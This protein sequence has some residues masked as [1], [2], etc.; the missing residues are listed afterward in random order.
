MLVA[1]ALCPLAVEPRRDAG[2]AGNAANCVIGD[3]AAELGV[4][5]D[6][7]AWTALLNVSPTFGGGGIIA[8]GDD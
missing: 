7:G 2:E 5:F 3:V 6:I 1:R 4:V 8:E